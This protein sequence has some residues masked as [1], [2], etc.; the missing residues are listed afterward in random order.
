VKVEASY[1]HRNVSVTSPYLPPEL[2]WACG[3]TPVR[4][5]PAIAFG[6][7]QGRPGCSRRLPSS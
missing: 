6:S 7:A 2:I 4:L 1:A 5:R 3:L